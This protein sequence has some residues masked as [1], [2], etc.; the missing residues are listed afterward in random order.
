MGY[1]YRVGHSGRMHWMH[2]SV[3]ALSADDSSAAASA[4]AAFALSLLFFFLLYLLCIRD[5]VVLRGSSIVPE[6]RTTFFTEP[7]AFD[8]YFNEN[9]PTFRYCPGQWCAQ[10]RRSFQILH[11]DSFFFLSFFQTHLSPAI[12]SVT[13]ATTT[14][15]RNTHAR[16]VI[17]MLWSRANGGI[18][19]IQL[20]SDR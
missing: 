18:R 12:L 5:V 10:C 20:T 3:Q 17:F 11:S 2:M 8:C 15:H 7:C 4:S 14:P 16:Y 9:S 6:S 1:V 13:S 19:F